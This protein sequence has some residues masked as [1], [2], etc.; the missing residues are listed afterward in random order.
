MGP[1]YLDSTCKWLKMALWDA[2]TRVFLDVQ[3]EQMRLERNLSGEESEDE[4]QEWKNTT[5]QSSLTNIASLFSK[6]LKISVQTSSVSFG[7][8]FCTAPNLLILHPHPGNVQL[9]PGCLQLPCPETFFVSSKSDWGCQRLWWEEVHWSW[10]GSRPPRKS[11]S[12]LYEVQETNVL[13]KEKEVGRDHIHPNYT[14]NWQG[15]SLYVQ[16]WWHYPPIWRIWECWEH[17]QGEF[18]I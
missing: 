4:K 8:R 17:L 6:R 13:R 7:T 15:S 12:P 5:S 18:K 16:E 1:Y 9:I 11:W 10:E 2:P 3:L 14:F